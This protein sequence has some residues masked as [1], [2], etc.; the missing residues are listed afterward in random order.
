MLIN[1]S[2]EIMISKKLY[3]LTIIIFS[4]TFSCS[5]QEDGF[6]K[7]E[8]GQLK[9]DI[10][11]ILGK[12]AKQSIIYKTEKYIWGP[13]EEF[14]DAIP[15]SAKLEVWQY[16]NDKGQLNLYFMAP[17]SHLAYKAFAPKGVV[18]ESTE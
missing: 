7:I 13:E 12:P 11:D 8:V 10:T 1:Q 6:S 4:M 5:G 3:S 18:Y 9:S 17:D 14:W 16:V 2:Y 15:D